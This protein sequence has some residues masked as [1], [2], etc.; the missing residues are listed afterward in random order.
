MSKNLDKV[1]SK[2]D[3]LILCDFS[4]TMSEEVKKEFCRAFNC[5]E[6]NYHT[7]LS[8]LSFF[9]ACVIFIGL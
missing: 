7:K 2:Y 1:M 3:I 5:T 6:K 4:S 8:L 9:V